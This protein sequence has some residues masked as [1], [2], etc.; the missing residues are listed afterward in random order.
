MED[1]KDIKDIKDIKY[2][3]RKKRKRKSTV[4]GRV[5]FDRIRE[6]LVKKGRYFATGALFI[7]LV[8]VVAF[9][10]DPKEQQ[11]GGPVVSEE[12]QKEAFKE[13]AYPEI[14]QL[15]E[16]YYHAYATGDL[17]T[18][19][20]L[21]TP[22]SEREQGYITLFSQYV[23]SYQNM[24]YYTKSGLDETSYLVNVYVEIKFEGVDTLAPGLDFFYIR[25]GEDGNLYI[26][27][28]Y[29][30]YNYK[31]MDNALDTDIDNLIKEFQQQEDVIALLKDAQA[32]FD[33]A[34]ASDENLANMLNVT[35]PDAISNWMAELVSQNTELMQESTEVVEPET[36]TTESETP[37]EETPESEAPEEETPEEET[38]E[39]S[40]IPEGTVITIRESINIREGMSTDSAKI[41]TAYQGEKVTVI[42]SYA[43]GW[44]KVKWN[45]KTGYI[46][47]DL[48]Q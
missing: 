29:S 32:K 39:V 44:T 37:E 23:E 25:T 27:N 43:E 10:T 6:F 5:N 40:A 3:Y 47:T 24:I 18:L 8:V 11:T 1:N 48:L 19:T 41:G 20:S 7:L 13:N 15:I 31:N 35:I 4:A 26:D 42:M 2:N 46:R 22:V 21:A 14:N 12:G 34:V 33:E 28:L 36:E 38:P 16:A 9:F 45:N 17:E 30:Q